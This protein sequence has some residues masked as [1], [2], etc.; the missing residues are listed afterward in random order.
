MNPLNFDSNEEVSFE[1]QDVYNDKVGE[2]GKVSSS[3]V[4]SNSVDQSRE[5]MNGGRQSLGN[6]RA[7]D[8]DV[9]AL[10]NNLSQVNPFALNK[11]RESK[12]LSMIEVTCRGKTRYHSITIRE[13]L[14]LVNDHAVAIDRAAGVM[15]NPNAYSYTAFPSSPLPPSSSSTSGKGGGFAHPPTNR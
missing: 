12:V 6:H 5:S 8:I 14:S 15:Y 9:Q 4:D 3:A 11:N 10:H 2:E 13:L 7:S 1:L